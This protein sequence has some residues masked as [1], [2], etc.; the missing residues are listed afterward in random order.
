MENVLNKTDFSLK[1][2]NIMQLIQL[3]ASL[4]VFSIQYLHIDSLPLSV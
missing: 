3:L 2:E 1:N 4:I